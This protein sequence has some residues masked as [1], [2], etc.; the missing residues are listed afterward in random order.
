MHTNEANSEIKW[1]IKNSFGKATALMMFTTFK[2]TRPG[3]KK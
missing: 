2:N 3:I 1:E